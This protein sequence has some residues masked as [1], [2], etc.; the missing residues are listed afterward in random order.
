MTSTTSVVALVGN[1]RPGSRTRTVAEHV[2]CRVAELIG[3]PDVHT[4]DLSGLSSE[5]FAPGARL[6]QA[7]DRVATARVVVVATPTYKATYT[8]LLKSFLD[9]YGNDG[10]AGVVAVPVQVAG[11][12]VHLL[13]AEVHLR[14]LLVELGAQVPTRALGLTESQLADLEEV[15][16]AWLETEG[17]RLAAAAGAAPAEATTDLVSGS[18]A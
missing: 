17:P 3:S 4:V 10:L 18:V 12:P 6:A 1:P 9:L 14:P 13:A 7:R 2:A 8:G 16:G 11:N 5:V 15:V